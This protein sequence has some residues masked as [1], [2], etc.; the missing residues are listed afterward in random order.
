ME[1]Q[2][3]PQN[4]HQLVLWYLLTWDEF[5]LKDVIN[6]S[7]FFKAQTRLSELEQEYGLLAKRQKVK[8]INRFNHK[9]E[10]N[11]YSALDKKRVLEIYNLIQEPIRELS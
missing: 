3:E 7:M 2:N 6:D 8:F 4:Q 11:V 5:S 10:Y 9:S 1:I